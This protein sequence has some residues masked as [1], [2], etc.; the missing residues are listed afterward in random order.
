[1]PTDSP[2]GETSPQSTTICLSVHLQRLG[3]THN[4]GIR[5][6]ALQEHFLNWGHHLLT[7]KSFPIEWDYLME[8]RFLMEW[9]EGS[10]KVRLGDYLTR[11]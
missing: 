10:M 11:I 8:K 4:L 6:E 3:R 1:M 9:G 5:L 7:E 2:F